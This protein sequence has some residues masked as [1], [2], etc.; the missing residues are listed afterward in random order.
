MRLTTIGKVAVGFIFAV[1]AGAAALTSKGTWNVI[2]GPKS[3]AELKAS[4]AA[5][6]AGRAADADED[7]DE[8]EDFE[9]DDDEDS[10]SGSEDILN[11]MARQNSAE[12]SDPQK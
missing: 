4:C 11:M 10:Q 12:A 5:D 3:V 9:E 7:D 2:G 1:G 6:K 8:F